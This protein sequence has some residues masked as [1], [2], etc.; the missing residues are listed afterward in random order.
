L[1]FRTSIEANSQSLPLRFEF[2]APDGE[3]FFNILQVLGVLFAFWAQTFIDIF[4]L[5]PA[6]DVLM[7]IL[8][9]ETIEMSLQVH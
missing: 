8:A 6:E 4:P 1:G 7:L 5:S 9:E 2:L 3:L